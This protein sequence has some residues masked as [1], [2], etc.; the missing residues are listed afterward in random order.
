MEQNHALMVV[1]ACLTKG[2]MFVPVVKNGQAS[3]VK[4]KLV[5]RHCHQIM[6]TNAARTSSNNPD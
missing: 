4:Q 2:I 3:T 6:Y 5:S 1:L